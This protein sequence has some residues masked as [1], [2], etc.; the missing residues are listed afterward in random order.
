MPQPVFGSVA[1]IAQCF[2]LQRLM[3]GY[4]K[5]TNVPHFNTIVGSS[6]NELRHRLTLQRAPDEDKRDL[7]LRSVQ[8]VQCLRFPAYRGWDTRQQQGHSRESPAAR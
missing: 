5:M 2:L 3:N 1:F 6:C 4:R 7:P 8:E